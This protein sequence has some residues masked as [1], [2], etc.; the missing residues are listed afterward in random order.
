M[1]GENNGIFAPSASLPDLLEVIRHRARLEILVSLA[2]APKDVSTL[3]D[4]LDLALHTISRHLRPLYGCQRS[5]DGLTAIATS[6]TIVSGRVV[7][8]STYSSV[9]SPP[10]SRTG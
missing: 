2:H 6:A 9:G 1:P 4:E 8:I 7:A 3:A 5:S 10:S